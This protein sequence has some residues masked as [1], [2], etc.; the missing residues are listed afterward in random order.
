M[1]KVLGPSGDRPPVV[2][3]RGGNRGEHRVFLLRESRQLLAYTTATK[4]T[5][6]LKTQKR[7]PVPSQTA[8]NFLR[9]VIDF[10]EAETRSGDGDV[11]NALSKIQALIEQ[12]QHHDN[13]H[14]AGTPYQSTRH[15]TNGGASPASWAGIAAS[16]PPPGHNGNLFGLRPGNPK[17]TN[18][19]AHRQIK[20]RVSKETAEDIKQR[21]DNCKY[22]VKAINEAVSKSGN[23][24]NGAQTTASGWQWVNMARILPSGDIY[25]YARDAPTAERLVHHH[26]EWEGVFGQSRVI[27]PTFPVVISDVRIGSIALGNQ[28]EL[29]EELIRSN[30]DT[31]TGAIIENV[32]WLGKHVE[33]KHTN[34]LVIEITNPEHANRVIAAERFNWEGTPKKVERYVKDCIK[35]QCFKCHAFNHTSPGCIKPAKCGYCSSQEHSTKE[36]PNPKDKKSWHCPGCGGNHP[37]WSTQCEIKKAEIEKIKQLKLAL[38]DNPFWPVPARVTPGVSMQGTPASTKENSVVN[39]DGGATLPESPTS[40]FSSPPTTA[41]RKETERLTSPPFTKFPPVETEPQEQPLLEEDDPFEKPPSAEPEPGEKPL[42]IEPEPRAPSPEPEPPAKTPRKTKGKDKKSEPKTPKT[43]A[44]QQIS[45]ESSPIK[46]NK[47]DAEDG[48]TEV[49]PKKIV[50][51]IKAQYEKGTIASV[52]LGSTGSKHIKFHDVEPIRQK[53]FQEK[54]KVFKTE[55][56]SSKLAPPAKTV[57]KSKTDTLRAKMAA[58]LKSIETVKEVETNDSEIQDTPD[59]EDNSDPSTVSQATN[60]SSESQAESSGGSQSTG[61]QTPRRILR[62]GKQKHKPT[63]L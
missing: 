10:I 62:N 47:G 30:P 34:A 44:K 57:G 26:R 45:F 11:L 2:G 40:T 15:S 9:S 6:G 41:G 16:P 25:V 46:P 13:S 1:D 12:Q 32:R 39:E 23:I 56:S 42:S 53:L 52:D 49:K 48:F 28:Q 43:P 51:A 24:N 60:P 18:P 27:V 31:L 50:K 3:A 59:G 21:P 38:L 8:E 14:T 5:S 29:I 54:V 61:G 22:I 33:G 17:L 55:A 36:H 37:A 4:A 63:L 20:L 19:I 7:K 58:K 35:P